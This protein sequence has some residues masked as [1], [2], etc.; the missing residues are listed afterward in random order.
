MN[1]SSTCMKRLK[2]E[3]LLLEKNPDDFISLSPS[4]NNIRQWLATIRA[5][6]DSVYDGFSFDLRI[7]VGPDYPLAPPVMKFLTKIFHPNVHYEVLQ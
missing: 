2:K 4:A 5:P 6:P 7:D 1:A 3:F